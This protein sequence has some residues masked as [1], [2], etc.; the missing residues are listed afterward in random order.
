[1]YRPTPKI[2]GFIAG[3]LVFVLI[4]FIPATGELSS[5][6]KYAAACAALMAV[7][8]ISEAI[9]LAATALLPLVL[10]PLFRIV[11]A[12]LTALAYADSNIFLFLG[13]FLIA[14]AMQR[15]NLHK[16]IALNII[17]LLGSSP[18]KILL[19]FMLATAFL[20]MWI[21]NTATTMMMVPIGI[22]VIE[23]VK[24][25]GVGNSEGH[26][27]K[28]NYRFGLA[29]MLGIAYA[30]SI[31]GV[32]TLVGTPPNIIFSGMVKNMFPELPEIDFVKWLVVGIPVV[33]VFLPLTWLFLSYV[34]INL[35]KV[36]IASGREIIQ[37]EREKLGALSI[38]EKLTLIVFISTSLGWIFRKDL[39][40]G[41]FHIPGWAGLLR[42]D[43]FVNDSTVAMLGALLL[44]VLPTNLKKSEFVLNWDWA[45]RVPWGILILFGG[46]LALAKG[47]QNSGLDIWIG[48]GFQSLKATKPLFLILVIC[49]LLT[50]LTE[51]TSNTAT[52]TMFLPVLAAMSITLGM[53]P[54]VL[55]IPAT[56]STSCAFMM[57]VATPPNAIVFGSGYVQIK[58]MAQKGF[59]LNLLGVILITLIM[60][61]VA[62]PFLG[63]AF[64]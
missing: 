34:G 7:W 30:S 60:Y 51:I 6:G 12:K 32:G 28:N 63:L 44:F 31:G 58:D 40:I 42:I 36:E 1:M 29:L 5:E 16:R 25:M 41:V 35:K 59:F 46:G 26:A 62:F 38:G 9:P 19:G 48:N 57:P 10:F 2:F 45:K 37:T 11:P 56:I 33:V 64:Y 13:G 39:D 27:N 3:I 18:R 55:M 49:L 23:Q 52:I 20:S 15:H 53:T 21:S 17:S 47:I 54:F 14:I 8:W 4:S 43:D 22:A 50:F 24:V 61:F